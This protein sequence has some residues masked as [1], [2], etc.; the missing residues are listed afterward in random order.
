ME[1]ELNLYL[2]KPAILHT[3]D[4]RNELITIVK[5]VINCH[6]GSDQCYFK[7]NN[8][9]RESGIHWEFVRDINYTLIEIGDL[10]KI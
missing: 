4:N 3:D 10:D 9:L 8:P 2:D 6:G 1:N 7:Y 5:K